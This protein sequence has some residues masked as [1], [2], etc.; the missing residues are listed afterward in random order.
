MTGYFIHPTSII[1]DGAMIGDG[2]RIWHFSHI[3][4][5]TV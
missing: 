2:C 4:G 5:D 3:M 1:D